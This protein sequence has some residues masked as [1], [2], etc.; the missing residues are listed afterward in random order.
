SLA[1]SS[2]RSPAPS[3]PSG[4]VSPIPQSPSS[5]SSPLSEPSSP[6][7]SQLII[8]ASEVQFDN[9]AG[10]LK[11][12]RQENGG[13]VRDAQIQL[14]ESQARM[15]GKFIQSAG[16]VELIQGL[17]KGQ[18]QLQLYIDS[19]VVPGIDFSTYETVPSISDLRIEGV[20]GRK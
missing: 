8:S 17:N 15:I 10:I 16:K 6:A 20:P 5:P 7:V 9:E 11:Y 13:Q 12:K 2:L 18:P 19:R 3:S 4:L 1:T 14:T